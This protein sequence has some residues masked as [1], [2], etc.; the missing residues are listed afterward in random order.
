MLKW[1]SWRMCVGYT[2]SCAVTVPYKGHACFHRI[3]AASTCDDS[4]SLVMKTPISS[5]SETEHTPWC[6]HKICPKYPVHIITFHLLTIHFSSILPPMLKS[7]KGLLPLHF[8]ILISKSFP[9]VPCVLCCN[10]LRTSPWQCRACVLEWHDKTRSHCLPCAP[11][12]VQAYC[13][14]DLQKELV[15]GLYRVLS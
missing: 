2:A 8:L 9:C 13:Q 15:S 1:Q 7:C 6:K 5:T 11:A 12:D 4:A 3:T 10:S 14:S